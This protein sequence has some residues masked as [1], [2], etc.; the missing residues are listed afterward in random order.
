MT[1][2]LTSGVSNDT[3]LISPGLPI[4][5]D[6]AVGGNLVLRST[7]NQT[8]GA[9]ILD[10]TTPSY[11]P[12]TGAL[13]VA[14][15]IAAQHSVSLG[16]MLNVLPTQSSL[17][18]I[19]C[20]PGFSG[21]YPQIEKVFGL[22]NVTNTG[23]RVTY[24]FN[25]QQLSPFVIT[26]QTAITG[27]SASNGIV[28]VSFANWGVNGD[29][30]PV[31]GQQITIAG[32]VP[33]GY[34]GTFTVLS[35][36]TTSVSYACAQTGAT[37]QL[38]IISSI[39]EFITITCVSPVQYNGTFQPI[40]C[41]TSTVTVPST[42]TGAYSSN[43]IL[44]SHNTY[45]SLLPSPIFITQS[46]ALI[47]T[48][49]PRVTIS[50]SNQANSVSATATCS[51]HNFTVQITGVSGTGA[52]ATMTY[53]V[54]PYPPF[55]VG[56]LIN[57]ANVT[58]VG[59]NGVYRVTDCTTTTVSYANAQSGAVSFTSNIGTVTGASIHNFTIT[60]PGTGYTG[61]PSIVVQDPS[62][63][64][65]TFDYV[66][67]TTALGAFV[68]VNSYLRVIGSNNLRY[69]YRV[70]FA[71]TTGID[72]IAGNSVPSQ[73]YDDF[74]SG[75]CRLRFVG[76]T[77]QPYASLG[78]S[79]MAIQ[80]AIHQVGSV[81]NVI[82]QAAGNFNTYNSS[83]QILASPPELPGGRT[84]V[85]QA[86]LGSGQIT[87]VVVVDG[88]SGYLNPPRLTIKTND[89]SALPGLGAV[90]YAVIGSPGEKPLISYMPV[91][92]SNNYYLDFGM[93][94]HNVVYMALNTNSSIFFDNFA[95]GAAP[96]TKGFPI[97]RKITLYI[98]ARGTVLITFTNLEATNSSTGTNT[99]TVTNGRVGRFE[100]QV[101]TTSNFHAGPVGST[102]GSTAGGTAL[103]V[104][105]ILYSS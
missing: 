52:T 32:V 72:Q 70:I 80:G 34:N 10:E 66:N 42:A 38:G 44:F 8:K 17:G 103:D 86:I 93:N 20:A 29:S 45:G 95:S 55:P 3:T 97:G 87:N 54:Q 75:N 57:V 26:Y 23:S 43:G 77:A 59:Y 46:S 84:A 78:S 41:T 89:N 74:T 62:P 100:F 73:T 90:L 1:V 37:S 18:N 47:S 92:N 19:V 24:T 33:A 56:S 27:V 88:G 28:T 96:Y 91:S 81:V 6:D 94:G 85:L 102:T 15:G 51:I 11:S 22:N 4:V 61:P 16:G 2:K 104:Y 21:F 25:G 35:A 76:I 63:I 36:S 83:V 5:G 58:P 49:A 50:P 30:R 64:P 14:G 101:L 53:S 82:I 39:G 98:K 65:S 31:N 9:V 7:S 69:I 71:G 68:T 79:S 13:Q 105:G 12:N 99:A 40:N 67:T 60:N 48:D